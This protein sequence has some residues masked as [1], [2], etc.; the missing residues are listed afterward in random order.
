MQCNEF[1]WWKGSRAGENPP[2]PKENPAELTM[3]F[4]Q[5]SNDKKCQAACRF[6][7]EGIKKPAPK[8]T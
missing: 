4:N 5:Y 2:A 1:W 8:G 6:L 3:R 7:A